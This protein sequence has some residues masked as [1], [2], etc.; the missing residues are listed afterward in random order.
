MTKI[1]DF[2]RGKTLF[3]TGSTGF[4]AKGLVE[5]IL[6]SAPEVG[7]LYLPIR[8]RRRPDRTVVSAEERLDREVLQSNAF[9]R[10]RTRHGAGFQ[11]FVQE[12]VA[13]VAWDLTLD[14]LGLDAETYDR[15]TGEVQVVIS[16]AGT[17]VFDEPVDQ[18][19]QSNTL[20]I[21]RIVEFARACREAIL[22]HV[23]TAYVSGKLSG[24][25]REAP[26][27]PGETVAHR[28]GMGGGD[29]DLDRE[30]ER[31]LAFTRHVQEASRLPEAQGAFQR[32]IRK[33]NGRAI[34]AR[35][36]E[37][38]MEAARH[39][40]LHRRLVDE[41][42]RRARS[43][44]WHDAYTLTKAMGEQMIAKMRGDLPT[45][46]VRPSII[47]SSLADPEPGWLEG[48]KVA[49][50]LIVHYSKGRLSDF[51]ADPA[52]VLDVIPVDVVV[53]AMLA[54]LPGARRGDIQV[55]QVATGTENPL[56]LG[57]MFELIHEYFLKNPMRTRQ[58]EPIP[59]HRWSFPSPGQFRRK[60]RLKYQIPLNALQWLMEN[61]SG[62]PW[63]RRLKRRV[64]MLEAT[65]DRVLA[66]SEIYSPYTNL[67][68]RFETANTR[69]LYLGLDPEDQKTF[70]FD[71]TR[72]DWREY[73][74][75]I[76]IPGL[77]RHV[78]KESI[79]GTP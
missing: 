64:S 16:I 13:A 70:N 74:Q 40:W 43:L 47:E 5:K 32:S 14:R 45:V 7:R 52:V 36:M 57:E 26:I 37:T 10:L 42:M 69:R 6:F 66:L 23:S 65:L 11:A 20:G 48:L 75:D 2:L 60:Y 72:I 34:S 58:G 53:N 63:S 12:K 15:L 33:Q 3:I 79:Y 18:A 27:L 67:K 44:G 54:A 29:Y 68:C 41:G 73:I 56:R 30:I 50:P 62:L 55:Y 39:R 46:I 21:G 35:R 25:V 22:L 78:L 4:V 51:P 61:L 77:K 19:L 8:P 49:D 76:H 59:V 24:S 38:L 9:D 28:L 31:I 17:V 71:V 1:A